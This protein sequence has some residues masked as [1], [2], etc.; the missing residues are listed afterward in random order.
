[1]QAYNRLHHVLSDGEASQ[2][3][4]FRYHGLTE[5]IDTVSDHIG[6]LYTRQDEEHNDS[7]RVNAWFYEQLF[8]LYAIPD[9]PRDTATLRS[10]YPFENTRYLR[11]VLSYRSRSPTRVF[12]TS[13]HMTGSRGTPDPA[14]RLC[15][16]SAL[17]Q[18]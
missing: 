12:A 2:Y 11:Q 9:A 15:W 10:A 8:Y 17:S 4:P 3:V 18:A 13:Q 5:V 14:L 16:C 6:L 1:M 7:V